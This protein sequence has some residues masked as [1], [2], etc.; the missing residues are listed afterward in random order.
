VR[1]FVA[2]VS[3]TEIGPVSAPSEVVRRLTE[4][5]NG[6]D[7]DGFLG[8]LADDVEFRTPM[9]TARHGLAAAK[10]F[11]RANEERGVFVEQDGA[12][13][14][15]GERVAVPIIVHMAGGTEMR[16]ARVFEIRDGKVAVFCVAMNRADA[17][18]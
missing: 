12:E 15:D 14:V 1:D 11:W 6:R 16:S 7:R 17:G 10:E 5:F 4:A 8:L 2:V 3:P 9:G 13:R 18:F